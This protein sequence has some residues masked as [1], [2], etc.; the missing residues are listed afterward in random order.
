MSGLSE[1]GTYEVF[2]SMNE[3]NGLSELGT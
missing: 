3:V 1:L 2:R